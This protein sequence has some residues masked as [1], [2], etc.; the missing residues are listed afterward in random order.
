MRVMPMSGRGSMTARQAAAGIPR[1]AGGGHGGGPIRRFAWRAANWMRRN[2]PIIAD[3][4]MA[5]GGWGEYAE[6]LAM[7]AQIRARSSGP[8][9]SLARC[10]SRTMIGMRQ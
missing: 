8:I 5:I 3:D 2:V 1:R 7:E 6:A 10:T 9:S 4:R